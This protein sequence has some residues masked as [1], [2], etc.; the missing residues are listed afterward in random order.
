MTGRKSTRP[1]KDYKEV[2][3]STGETIKV[4]RVPQSITRG[5]VPA[6][7]RPLRPVVEMNTKAGPQKRAIKSDDPGWEEYQDA[8]KEWDDEKMR[9]QEAVTLCMA[10][11]SYPFPEAGLIFEADIKSLAAAGLLAIPDNEYSKKA[12]WI[13]TYVLGAYNDELEVDFALQELSGVPS[14]VIEELK[15]NFRRT[16]LGQDLEAMGANSAGADTRESA[17][18]SV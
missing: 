4:H 12:M 6:S 3:L 10:L 15:E 14:E 8:V 1:N 18:H 11:K 5:V 2:E 9:M 17:E 7:P 13:R 16:L